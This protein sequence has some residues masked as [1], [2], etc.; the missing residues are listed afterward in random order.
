[1]LFHASFEANASVE[2]SDVYRALVR[3]GDRAATSGKFCRL[4]N[5]HRHARNKRENDLVGL[6]FETKA[7]VFY[8]GNGTQVAKKLV[9]VDVIGEGLATLAIFRSR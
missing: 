3:V 8:T 1:M 6:H 9:L 7:S 4:T 5:S 2:P